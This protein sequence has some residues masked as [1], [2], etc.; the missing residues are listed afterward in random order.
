MKFHDHSRIFAVSHITHSD[1]VIYSSDQVN[2]NVH[3]PQIA[4][5]II[6]NRDE[7]NPSFNFSYHI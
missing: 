7:N 6:K 5:C 3:P 2:K 4:H 1:L